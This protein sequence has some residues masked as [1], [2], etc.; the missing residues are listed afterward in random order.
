MSESIGEW[1]ATLMQ[2]SQDHTEAVHLAYQRLENAGLTNRVVVHRYRCRRGCSLA[3]VIRIEDVV[4]ARTSDY[5]LSPGMNLDKSVAEARRKNTLDGSRHW[6]GHTFDVAGL[7]PGGFQVA[8]RHV[9][10][11]VLGADLLALVENVTPGHPGA[12]T[13]L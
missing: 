1:W 12:P 3:T 5:K 2:Q 11:V 9:V 4:L 8:C 13:L 10:D 7:V 6:P